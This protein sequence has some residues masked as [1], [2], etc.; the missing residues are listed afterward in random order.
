MGLQVDWPGHQSC[1]RQAG[2]CLKLVWEKK[3]GSESLQTAEVQD[4]LSLLFTWHLT[5]VMDLVSPLWNLWLLQESVNMMYSV[6]C[7]PMKE[8]V[9]GAVVLAREWER[10]E[11]VL[12]H[13]L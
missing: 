7:G 5:Q 1:H 2:Q 6:Q 4:S 12:V 3:N 8:Q 13:K 11:A 9:D 10:S